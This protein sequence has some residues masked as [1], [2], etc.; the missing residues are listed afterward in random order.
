MPNEKR[1][2]TV[3][4]SK[5]QNTGAVSRIDTAPVLYSIVIMIRNCFNSE[6]AQTRSKN[7]LQSET[8]AATLT[9]ANINSDVFIRVYSIA[10]HVSGGKLTGAATF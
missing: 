8:E 7:E 4:W 2:G 9:I 5:C 3:S 6:Q 10:A 1:S